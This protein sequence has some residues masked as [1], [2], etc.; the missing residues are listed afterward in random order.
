MPDIMP[1]E[2]RPE[3]RALIS[4]VV[5]DGHKISPQE[6][7][8]IWRLNQKRPFFETEILWVERGYHSKIGSTEKGVGYKHMLI[9]AHELQ[10]LGITP[11]KLPELV[12][13]ATVVGIYLGQ[14]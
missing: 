14:Q 3:W 13:A 4:E 7:M 9:H 11:E 6:V 8:R 2:L 10:Q 5:N 12:E 1:P